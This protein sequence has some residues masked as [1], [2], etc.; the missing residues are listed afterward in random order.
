VV[1]GQA[2][3]LFLTHILPFELAQLIIFASTSGESTQP[4]KY[5]SFIT[6][7]REY[8]ETLTAKGFTQESMF[9]VLC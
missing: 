5:R 8:S 1:S 6:L 4:S 3:G 7:S 2:K 9:Q